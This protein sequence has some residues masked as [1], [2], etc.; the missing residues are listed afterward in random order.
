[1]SLSVALLV[2][3]P[4]TAALTTAEAAWWAQHAKN[5]A[6]QRGEGAHNAAR[7]RNTVAAPTSQPAYQSAEWWSGEAMDVGA[8]AEET[9][10][11]SAE[12]AAVL[13]DNC[14]WGWTDECESEDQRTQLEMVPPCLD[15][16]QKLDEN[17]EEC[18]MDEPVFQDVAVHTPLIPCVTTHDGCELEAEA[19]L[20]ADTALDET[21]FHDVALPLETAPI[22][23]IT[24]HDGCELEAEAG[25]LPNT[26]LPV[27]AA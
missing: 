26:K 22:P 13:S 17:E 4:C 25:I 3:L 1:M 6:A 27:T 14:A 23:C 8:P 7:S 21:V 16:P 12:A 18:D 20:V 15:E 9:A 24:T 5:L 19:G 11:L 10:P 2:A